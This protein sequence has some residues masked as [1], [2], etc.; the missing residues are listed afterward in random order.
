[1]V[2]LVVICIAFVATACTPLETQFENA[3]PTNLVSRHNLNVTAYLWNDYM[4]GM[5]QPLRTNH[6]V[7]IEAPQT[8]DITQVQ[9]I[10]QI[11]TLRTNITRTFTHRT[12]G[13]GSERGDFR[14]TELFRLRSGEN[15]T[16]HVSILYR[17]YTQTVTLTG[18]VDVTH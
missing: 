13:G 2:A 16:L 7:A 6:F 4:P 1:M 11:V 14:S 8:V 17:G 3:T 15:Y 9:M 10:V 12:Y 18:T 5:P